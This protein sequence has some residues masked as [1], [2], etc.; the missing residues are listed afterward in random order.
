M[1]ISRSNLTKHAIE[2][3]TTRNIPVDILDDLESFGEEVKCRDGGYKI[4]FSKSSRTQIRRER[5]RKALKALEKFKTLY[6]VK[7]GDKIVTVAHSSKPIF[8]H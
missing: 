6:A 8:S 1:E 4:A 3:M 2:R 5:G 7:C